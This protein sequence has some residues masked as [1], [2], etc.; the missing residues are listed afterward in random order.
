MHTLVSEEAKW[1]EKPVEEC[2]N[3]QR[4]FPDHCQRDTVLGASK[5]CGDSFPDILGE[6]TEELWAT[7]K[8]GLRSSD[9]IDNQTGQR[10]VC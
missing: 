3:A 4:G 6:A 7:E 5:L 10:A 8:H 9:R 1:A 2:G